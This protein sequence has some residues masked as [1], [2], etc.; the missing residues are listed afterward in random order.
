MAAP[1][2]EHP[3]VWLYGGGSGHGFKHGPALAEQMAAGLS[4]TA[5]LPAHFGL[6]LARREGLSEPLGEPPGNEPG[7]GTVLAPDDGLSP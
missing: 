5:D 6:G 3:A 4:G 1:H 7:R 2:P